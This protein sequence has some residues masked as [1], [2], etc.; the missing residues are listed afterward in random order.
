MKPTTGKDRVFWVAGAVIVVVYALVPVAWIVSLSLKK[1]ADLTDGK[2][3][4]RSVSLENYR[5][6]FDSSQFTSALRNSMRAGLPIGRNSS[7]AVTKCV[8]GSAPR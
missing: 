1:P 4:P 8:E 3:F 5:S 2:F 7:L 6:I